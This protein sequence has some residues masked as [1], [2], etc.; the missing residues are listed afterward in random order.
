[1]VGCPS[2]I[3]FL[4]VIL[5]Y[6]LLSLGRFFGLPM[7]P[8]RE[9][10][11]DP[12]IL[13]FPP[14]SWRNY[15]FSSFSSEAELVEGKCSRL[16]FLQWPFGPRAFFFPE[17]PPSLAFPLPFPGHAS[18]FI[19]PPN[20]VNSTAADRPAFWRV[21]PARTSSVTS[22]L[23]HFI[24]FLYHLL[25]SLPFSSASGRFIRQAIPFFSPFHGLSFS[26]LFSCPRA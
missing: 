26:V 13:T 15:L 14:S 16:L 20:P 7:S 11:L 25:S 19:S 21:F 3:S 5:L 12:V 6:V 8:A 10:T 23:T 18:I 22:P 17:A 24:F 9:Y 4:F 2:F 1:V